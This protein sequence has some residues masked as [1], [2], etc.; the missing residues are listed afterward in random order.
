MMTT[1]TLGGCPNRNELTFL[2]RTSSRNPY[3]KPSIDCR[4]ASRPGS[5]HVLLSAVNTEENLMQKLDEISTRQHQGQ[6]ISNNLVRKSFD[7]T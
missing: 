4:L 7:L 6:N 5:V 2:A 3:F 1:K